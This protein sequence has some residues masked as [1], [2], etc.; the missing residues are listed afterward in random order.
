MG[1]S[2]NTTKCFHAC[3]SYYAS[4]SYQPFLI[5]WG[6]YRQTDQPVDL[7]NKVGLCVVEFVH[8]G[9]VP[10]FVIALFSLVMFPK[11]IEDHD[12]CLVVQ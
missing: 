4:Y 9:S 8:G 10:I 3:E 2:K 11:K 6:M 5:K 1:S 12:R 7:W